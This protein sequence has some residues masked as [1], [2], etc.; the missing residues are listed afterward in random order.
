M[1]RHLVPNAGDPRLEIGTST[2]GEQHE[3]F[4]FISRT[5]GMRMGTDRGGDRRHA[6]PPELEENIQEGKWV[7]LASG[8][9][10]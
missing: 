8:C 7:A 1:V 6:W 4:V 10:I 3:E 5:A 9:F 2:T